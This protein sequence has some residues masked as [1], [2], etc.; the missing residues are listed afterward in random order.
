MWRREKAV[1]PANE[2][3]K[4]S[5]EIPVGFFGDSGKS[6]QSLIAEMLIN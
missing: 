6:L 3:G 5:S 1:E 4:P 2:K